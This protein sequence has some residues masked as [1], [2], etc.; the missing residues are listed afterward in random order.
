[1]PTPNATADAGVGNIEHEL[2]ADLLDDLA[3][4]V[5]R[6]LPDHLGEPVD[7]L[8]RHVVAHDL[9]ERREA[10]QVDEQDRAHDLA[11]HGRRRR[12][13][14][15]EV[16]HHVFTVG[17]LPGLA[18]EVQDGWLDEVDHRISDAARRHHQLLAGQTVRSELFVDVQVDGAGHRL[19]HPAQ[20]VGQDTEDLEQRIQRQAQL[21]RGREQLQRLHILVVGVALVSEPGPRPHPI[22]HLGL[23]AGP[24]RRLGAADASLPARPQGPAEVGGQDVDVRAGQPRQLLRRNPATVGERDQPGPLQVLDPEIVPTA[25][26]TE[27]LPLTDVLNRFTDQDGDLVKGHRR[28][29]R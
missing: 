14:L 17:P 5:R 7:D 11:R 26:Q 8:G 10:A 15:D 9:G 18:E 20:R 1:M 6:H 13:L 16:Q 22:E 28:S 21:Q 19:G 4:A 27:S 23:D 2:V 29:R 25:H 12:R 24:G 3:V